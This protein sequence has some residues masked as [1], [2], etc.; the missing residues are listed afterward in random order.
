[1]GKLIVWNIASLDGY[2]EGPEPW[3]LSLHETIWGD[4]LSEFSETQ[5]ADTE[6]LVFGRRTYE[7]MASYWANETETGPIT[8]AMNALPKYVVSNTLTAAD[9]NNTKIVSGDI[10][11]ALRD[12]KAGS[13]RNLYVFGSADLLA[14]LL[15]AGLVD[16][17]RLGLAPLLLGRGNLLFKPS[18]LRIDLDLIKTQP[19]K[20]G[21][22]V[23]TCGLKNAR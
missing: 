9:W 16:E 10:V 21:G 4:E 15:P 23:I 5:L 17:Y 13:E 2:F 22:I 6:A 11:Q 12:I 1:M 8:D 7:G 3:D 19:L 14:T 18:D 20:N